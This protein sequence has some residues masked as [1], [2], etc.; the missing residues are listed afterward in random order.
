M[1]LLCPNLQGEDDDAQSD[2]YSSFSLP[3]QH[4]F[5]AGKSQSLLTFMKI[6]S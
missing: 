5:G 4:S 3:I 1:Y 6:A 2:S